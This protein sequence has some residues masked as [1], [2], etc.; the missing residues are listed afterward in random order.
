MTILA[1]I[2]SFLKHLHHRPL[3]PIRDWM[4][5]LTLS[6]IALVS[7]IVWNIWAFNTVATG[8]VIGVTATST[9]PVFN[10]TA[11]DTIHTIFDER[12]NEEMKYETGTYR[13]VDPS[14]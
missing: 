13:F 10:Q 3:D 11:L 1:T 7:I 14:Q 8:G 2:N 12:A 9:S 4:V 6:A 5:M